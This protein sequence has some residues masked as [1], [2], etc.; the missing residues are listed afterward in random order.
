MGWI[1]Y[2]LSYRQPRSALGRHAKSVS[3]IPAA[4]RIQNLS[5]LHPH[6]PGRDSGKVLPSSPQTLAAGHSH[7]CFEFLFGVFRLV[8]E[9]CR[10]DLPPE[11][12]VPFLIRH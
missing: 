9:E 8:A 4:V 3:C 7:L 2:T 12:D 5:V 6:S 10:P 1:G 11:Q